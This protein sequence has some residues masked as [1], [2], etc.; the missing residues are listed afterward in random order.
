[1]PASPEFSLHL[2]QFR[3]Q[4]FTDRLPQD[5]ELSL[6]RLP[7]DVRESGKV[8]H[9]RLALATL[10]PPSSRMATELQ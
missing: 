2:P 3:L 5:R 9:F 7:A 6:S 4:A 8:E 10:L 1:M